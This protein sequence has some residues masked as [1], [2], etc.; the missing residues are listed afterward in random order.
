LLEV[1]LHPHPESDFA[2]ANSLSGLSQ[3]ARADQSAR[4]GEAGN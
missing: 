2:C 3:L 4:A 1:Y